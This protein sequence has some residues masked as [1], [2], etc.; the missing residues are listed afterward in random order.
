MGDIEFVPNFGAIREEI[1]KS[2]KID[3]LLLKQYR[4]LN[5]VSSE[6]EVFTGRLRKKVGS[7]NNEELSKNSARGVM[8]NAKSEKQRAYAR[9]LFANAKE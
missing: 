7:S 4:Q 8:R 3:S 9:Y 6:T 1:L 5:K 2:E